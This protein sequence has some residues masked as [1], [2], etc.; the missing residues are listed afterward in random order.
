MSDVSSQHSELSRRQALDKLDVLDTAPEAVFDSL[1]AM[2]AAI[3]DTP[4]SLLTLIDEERQ[5]FKANQGLPGIAETPRNVAFCHHA[6]E[7]EQLFEVGD[8][9][10][11]QRFAR[12]PLVTEKPG[13]RFYAGAPLCMRDGARIGTL[14]VIDQE[15]REL[16]EWQ[17]ELL[18][19]LAQTAVHMLE[20]RRAKHALAEEHQRRGAILEGTRAGTWEWN[21]KTGELRTN[22]R[23]AEIIGS[24]KDDP[25]VMTIEESQARSH[26]EDLQRVF[27]EVASHVA[28]ES[29]H[30]ECEMRVRHSDGQWVWV[31][32]SGRLLTRSDTEAPEWMFG[33]RIDITER[34]RQEDT[35]RRSEQLLNRTG[36]VA[37]VG[38]WELDLT[39]NTL[40][41]SEQT[42]RIH[43]VTDTFQPTIESAI[44]FYAP[45]SRTAIQ[46]A[47]QRAIEHGLSFDLE[48]PL[49]QVSGNRLWVRTVGQ[50]EFAGQQ[51]VRLFGAIQD[52]TQQ[53]RQRHDLE[54]AHQRLKLANDSGRIGVWDYDVKTQHLEWDQCMY[55]LYGFEYTMFEIDYA[56]WVKYLHPED[57]AVTENAMRD[58]LAGLADFD[59]EFRIVCIDGNV[60]YLRAT[61]TVTRDAHGKALRM[62][63]ANWDVTPLRILSSKLDNERELLQVTLSSIGDGVI[64]ANSD[65]E[66]SWLNPVAERLTGWSI[67]E[68]RGRPLS[69]VFYIVDQDS[70]RPAVSPVEQCIAQGK[71]VGLANNTVL[72]A[73]DRSEY[74]IED[75][76]AP[77]RSTTGEMLG[78][79]LVFHDVT[80][81]RQ[82]SNEMSYRA[83]HDALT[84]LINRTEFELQLQQS[85]M[86]AQR[87]EQTCALM[88]IDL[89]QFKL[90]NDACGHSAGDR[91][92]VQFASL[93]KKIARK[94]DTFARLGGDE[95]G[96]L[97]EN[98]SAADAL[99]IGEQI[100]RRMDEYRFVHN[101]KRFR[102]GAS[103]GLASFNEQWETTAAIVQAA[104]AACYA[105]K[106]NGRNR[107]HLWIESDCMLHAR[108]SEMQWVQRLEQ[109]SDDNR[110]EL[111]AQRIYDLDDSGRAVRAEILLRLRDIDGAVVLPNAF[112]SAAERYHLMTRIDRWVLQQSINHMCALSSLAQ[113]DRLSINLSGQSIGDPEFRREIIAMLENAGSD[114]CACVCLEITETTA[115]THLE[116]ANLFIQE[117]HSLGV[118]VALDDFGSGTASFGY[119]KSLA[120]DIL[121]IDGQFVQNIVDDP[122][123]AATVRC[124]VDVAQVINVETVAEYVDSQAALT[125]LRE[126][127]VDAAQGFWLHE[128]E[129]IDRLLEK[130]QI[131]QFEPA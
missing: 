38:G 41:W 76:A 24:A 11:D 47:L 95:F 77:I 20:G 63:G 97:L 15:P 104:D 39:D 5:W 14:C 70:R 3:C 123:D 18:S 34:K 16:T 122:L 56:R 72:I 121:K 88:F 79:V 12:N 22:K 125:R 55:R 128:P 87:Y 75:S 8:A 44:E 25:E 90:V 74:G 48:L 66:V 91:L 4:I 27:A 60:R 43:G 29:E 111:Y 103:I 19:H 94:H 119:L 52:I 49:D 107:V 17:R 118:V 57:R 81:Q 64:T 28:G 40:I 106:E 84:G 23:W 113:I 53:V 31:L 110:F 112:L 93:I 83:S 127:N 62:V 2:A 30:Y 109:A 68:A 73:R 85:L 100:C 37:A 101:S 131:Q 117:V 71:I 51:P 21:V 67:E 108:R 10:K 58:A 46:L 6:I 42:R 45:E 102:V 50:A 92:L 65:G 7:G 120:V 54:F 89:D 86:K 35:L 33:T 26:P 126:F 80:E 82:L 115:I 96:I 61:A 129:P 59:T 116:D 36:E 99:I 124:F 130:T 78:V 114:V 105:A 32:D 13:L 98:C 9:T 1:V 69:E